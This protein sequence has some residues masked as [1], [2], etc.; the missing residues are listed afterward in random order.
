MDQSTE[1][2]VVGLPGRYAL[3]LFELA[4]E[5][6]EKDFVEKIDQELLTVGDIINSN[7]DLSALIKSPIFSST[8][9]L[10]LM[11][12]I[13]KKIGVSSMINNFIGVLCENRRLSLLPNI[14]RAFHAHLLV[15]NKKGT[16]KL[17]TAKPISDK[18]K[19]QIEKILSDHFDLEV[20]INV[21][22]NEEIL[23]GLIVQMGSKMIDSSLLTRLKSIKNVMNEA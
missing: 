23:G 19:G 10:S 7:N 18:Q 3:S 8:E 9:Q 16:A 5:E 1:D 2:Y 6:D 15:I 21:E 12:D 13:L 22:V 11:T 20:D 4:Q 14:I 17:I